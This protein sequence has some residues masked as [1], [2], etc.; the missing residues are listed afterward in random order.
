MG[1][2]MLGMIPLSATQGPRND[3]EA[4]LAGAQGHVWLERLKKMLRQPKTTKEYEPI[5]E[6]VFQ[7]GIPHTD[8]VSLGS[9]LRKAK[10]KNNDIWIPDVSSSFSRISWEDNAMNAPPASLEVRRIRRMDIGFLDIIQEA[11]ENSLG[12]YKIKL[13]QMF[14]A[15]SML[16]D[17]LQSLYGD[18][19]SSHYFFIAF[20]DTIDPHAGLCMWTTMAMGMG[21]EV[22]TRRWVLNVSHLGSQTFHGIRDHTYVL[23][24]E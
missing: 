13:P 3:L 16:P 18:E 20:V 19:R 10:S 2:N 11:K 6:T 8:F 4:K 9:V 21:Y 7:M 14:A 12:G 22:S 23:C 15:M 1:N 5:L 24:H 17:K